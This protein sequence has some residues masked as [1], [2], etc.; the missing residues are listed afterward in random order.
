MALSGC[1]FLEAVD[2]DG[3]VVAQKRRRSLVVQ[4]ETRGANEYAGDQYFLGCVSSLAQQC[5]PCRALA[6]KFTRVCYHSI[7]FMQLACL[8]GPFDV[9]EARLRSG[10]LYDDIMQAISG[11]FGTLEA[12]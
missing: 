3:A 4:N 9:L 6:G 8:C 5:T 10:G 1:R 7:F 11:C 2:G 12:H